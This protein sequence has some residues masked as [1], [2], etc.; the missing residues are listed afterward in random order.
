MFDAI[1]P[2]SRI[3]GWTADDRDWDGRRMI[4]MMID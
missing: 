3:V 1:E 4:G 2:A